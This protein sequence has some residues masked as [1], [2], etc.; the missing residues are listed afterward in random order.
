MSRV[1]TGDTRSAWWWLAGILGLALVLRLIGL[2]SG[3]WYDEIVSLVEFVRLPAADL[4][5]T[6]TTPNN[7]VLYSL[8][9]KGTIALFGETAW[10]LRLP[11]ALAGVASIGAIAWLG[12]KFLSRREALTAAALAA[13]TYHHVWFSQNARGYTGLLLLAL[14]GT[15]LFIE[16]CRRPR[17]VTWL[18]YAGVLGVS[19]FV[20]LTAVFVFA[21]HGLVY[22]AL[23]SSERRRREVGWLPVLGFGS[24]VLLTLGLYAALIPQMIATF[25]AQ[26]GPESANVK[27]AN[28]TN[29]L[30]TVMESA[31]RFGLG[32]L[33]VP[34]L[35][36]G[37]AIAVTGFVGIWRRSAMVASLLVLN[38]PL[39]LIALLAIDFHVWPRYFFA[40]VGFGLLVFVHGLFVMGEVA[41]G[42][43][44]GMRRIGL[45][46]ARPGVAAAIVCAIGL[47]YPL[48]HYYGVPKQDFVGARNFVEE[49]RGTGERVATAGLAALPYERLYA[50]EWVPLED[51]GAL[52]ALEDGGLW[53]VYTFE[54]HMRDAHPDILARLESG[55]EPVR[56]FRGTVGG[57]TIHVWHRAASGRSRVE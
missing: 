57:G 48:R 15:G 30:W 5:T 10:A 11:A 45:A 55:Y 35:L 8:A 52:A 17:R 47:A 26:A 3:L 9:A 56:E 20:H 42:R 16:G 1:G 41:A 12:Q 4:L 31:R 13:V 39:T 19:M 6:Y 27:I 53:V 54:D 25:G 43:V 50:P 28:W 21:S 2:N 32:P 33:T 46:G 34:A 24:G 22:L 14:V 23:L 51:V 44:P 18:A 7:H 36:S 29:P 38:V 40:N 49:T 37:A